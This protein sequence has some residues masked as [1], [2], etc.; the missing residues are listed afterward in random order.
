MVENQENIKYKEVHTS[1]SNVVIYLDG[2]RVTRNNVQE[3]LLEQGINDLKISGISKYLDKDSVRVKGSG[4]G[5]KATLVDVEV[6]YIYKERTGHEQLDKL[7]EQLKDLLKK[8][9]IINADINHYNW[10][11]ENLTAMLSNFSNEFPKFFAAGESDLQN[12]KSMHSYSDETISNTQVKLNEL[13]EQ[14]EKLNFEIEKIQREIQQIGGEGLKVEEYYD[15]KISIEANDPGKFNLSIAYQIKEANWTPSYDVL[16]TENGTSINYRAEIINQT[17]EDWE[18]VELEV[19]TATFKPVRI[20]EPEP[21]YIQEYTYYDY[22]HSGAR[23]KKSKAPSGAIDKEK[24]FLMEGLEVRDE[25]P[26]SMEVTQATFSSDS[27]GVEHYKIPKRMTIKADGNPHPVLLKEFEVTS[28]RLFY[29]NSQDQQLVAQ[30]KIKNGESTLLPGKCKCYV[31]GDFVGETDI[32]AIS[33]GEEFKLGTR[34]SF[35]LKVEKKLTKRE[36]GKK[37]ITKGKLVNE[38]GYEIKINNYRKKESEIIIIDRI[39][40]SRS[41]DIDVDPEQKDERRLDEY[42]SPV[43]T[44][45][46][47]GIA[48]YELKLKPEEEFII[49]YHYRVSYKKEIKIDPPLP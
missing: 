39:P 28:K 33:P 6:Q 19:S 12:L 49:K 48:T 38:Y 31:D 5:V 42:F 1:I 22:A 14:L 32:K 15:I 40:H 27:F 8:Q 7:Q 47:L 2:A 41:A 37:G 25:L 18:D 34:R 24:D 35:E 26:V 3:I 13:T 9:A 17:L 44:K 30:E 21:W 36:V 10:V 16:I 46:E 11:K 20:I 43:P 4:I 45:F 23:Y 29:W